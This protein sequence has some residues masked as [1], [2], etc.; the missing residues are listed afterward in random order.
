MHANG[1]SAALSAASVTPAPRR[2]FYKQL[3]FWVLIGLGL[4]VVFGLAAPDQGKEAKWL[5]DAFLQIIKAVAG[6]VIFVT[7]VV[8]VASMGNMA[9][10]GGLAVRALLFFFCMT[11]IALAL[12]L[13]VG[14]LFHP[15]TGLSAP[16]SDTTAAQETI[17][18]A[19]D[20]PHGIVGFLT[21]TLLPSSFVEPFVENSILQVIVLALLTSAAVCAL[22]DTVRMQVVSV[23]EVISKVLFGVIRLIM[24]MAPLGAFGGMAFTIAQFGGGALANLAK[25]AIVFWGTAAFF[26]FVVLGTVARVVGGFSIFKFLRL[27]KDELLILLGTSSSETVLPR[28]LTKLEAAGAQRDVVGVVLPTG[29]AFNA[30]GGCIYLTLGALFIVQAAGADLSLGQELALVALMLLTSKGAAGVSGQGLVALVVSLQAFG[31]EFFTPEAITIGISLVVGIDRIMSEGRTLVNVIGNSVATM[32]IAKLVGERDD[33]RF[34]AVLEN[35]SLADPDLIDAR[36]AD[37]PAIPRP[38]PSRFPAPATA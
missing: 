14:H 34:A 1:S 19:S 9:K 29:Y 10:A 2:R 18:E 28:L 25:L 17:G 6:P 36:A 4:G 32:T 8:G 38:E 31:G 5:A 24:W 26:V 21:G 20:A 13:M 16:A 3:W 35:P 27:L 15:G 11:L 22:A 30:D 12:G 33:H 7:V 37:A 23:F